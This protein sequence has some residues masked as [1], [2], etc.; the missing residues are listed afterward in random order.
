MLEL[1]DMKKPLHLSFSK[2]DILLAYIWDNSIV[3]GECLEWQKSRHLHGY[4]LIYVDKKY[5]LVTRVIYTLL[6]GRI[7][8][9]NLCVCHRCDNPPCISIRHLW[10]GT[11]ADNVLDMVSKGRNKGRN[12]GRIHT[13]IRFLNAF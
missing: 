10:L 7:L 3:V 11:R 5:R 2:P 8:P 13:P 12:Q 6:K 9:Y 1:L 4:G